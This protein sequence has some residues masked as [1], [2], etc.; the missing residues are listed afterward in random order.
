VVT[1]ED[2]QKCEQLG[3]R[4]ASR[5]DDAPEKFATRW[6]E[7]MNQTYP[8]VERYLKEGIAQQVDGMP[9]VQD[10]HES[11]MGVIEKFKT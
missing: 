1:D 11:V 10:V 4:V 7:F 6:D 2:R 8:V 3:G 5:P 9:S